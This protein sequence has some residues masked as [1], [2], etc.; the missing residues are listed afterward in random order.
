MTT[1]AVLCPTYKRPH[2]LQGVVDN[3]KEATK[4]S[5]TLYFGV[6]PEDAASY[7]AAMATGAKVV[8]NTGRMGYSDTIQTMYEL[9]KEPFLWHGNDDFFYLPNWDEQP[10]AMFE[11]PEVMVVGCRQTPTDESFS[12]VSFI[13]RKYIEEQSGVIDM[14]NRL[15]YPYN[16]NYQDTEMTQTAQARNVWAKCDAPCIDHQHPG[17]NGGAKD[18]TY[19]KNDATV[20][21]DERTF[22]SRK[23]LWQNIS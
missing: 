4:N 8:I 23:R 7:E 9:S 11:R 2:K 12:A 19:R 5:Y 13:R 3:L 10:I 1:L 20:G 14:P 16:H 15:F 17:F 6:E 21:L 18:E 22:E